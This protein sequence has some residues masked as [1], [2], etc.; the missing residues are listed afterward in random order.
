VTEAGG[1]SE[2]EQASRA[3]EERRLVE[4]AGRGSHA[5][6][7]RLYRDHV[8]KVYGLCLRMTANAATAEDCT[9]ETFIQAWRGLARFERRSSFGTWLHR[10]AVNAVL[11]RRRRRADGKD[12]V[13]LL[14]DGIA[15]TLASP[16]EPD[17]GR[18]RDLEAAI[19][20]LP[21]GARRV[22]V[23]AGLY[24]YSHEE[25]AVM[26]GLAVGTCKAQLH[27]ARRLLAARLDEVEE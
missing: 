25:T 20:S 15:D 5:A 18:F 21:D 11:A 10:I 1:E 2:F 12:D 23:L 14:D 26:L 19:A 24:G 7:E 13:D 4:A 9:Q 22:L 16:N 6:F 17:P 8:G 27:R 3:A